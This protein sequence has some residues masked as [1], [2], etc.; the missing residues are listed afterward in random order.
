MAGLE[1]WRQ[2]DIVRPGE[3]PHVSI[4]G[5]GGI[6]GV[7]ALTLAKMG[8]QNLTVYDDDKVESHNLPNQLYR[9]NDIGLSKVVALQGICK[10]FAGVDVAVVAERLNGHAING[11]IV[12]GVDSMN[13]RKEIWE[14]IKFNVNVPL[15]VEGRM[16]AEVMRIYS[17]NPC[18]PTDVE[19]YGG[20]L[21]DDN[22]AI[23]A[24]CTARAIVYT[25]FAIAAVI[26]SQIRK[27]A[28]GEALAR[29]VILDMVT[30]TLM[31]A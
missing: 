5:V 24:P 12:S 21:Y 10:E 17:V 29:E 28:K 7:T 16:G 14:R 1:F 26:A 13:S 20:T 30:L 2:L 23:E 15:Y 22:E 27:F 31:T 25:G 11:V 8:V 18:L 9:I 3:L 4:V 19:M 6:G